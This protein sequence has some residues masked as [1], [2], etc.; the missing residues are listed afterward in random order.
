MSDGE[1][2]VMRPV[3][4]GMVRLESLKDGSVDL[5]DIAMANEAIDVEQENSARAQ[6]AEKT[7]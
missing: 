6:A 3:L 1:G 7:R 4:R 2:W 5:E